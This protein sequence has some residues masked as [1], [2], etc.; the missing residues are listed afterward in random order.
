MPCNVIHAGYMYLEFFL[1]N[2]PSRPAR[3]FR[4]TGFEDKDESESTDC[5][6][7]SVELDGRGAMLVGEAPR[8]GSWSS[9][10]GDVGAV[11]SGVLM[12]GKRSLF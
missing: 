7:E 11:F 6:M 4:V 9:N 12:A 5:E 10:G 8:S 2:R 1:L 3:L